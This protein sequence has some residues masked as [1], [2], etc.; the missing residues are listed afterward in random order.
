[1]LWLE[2]FTLW[3]QLSRLKNN[4]VDDKRERMWHTLEALCLCALNLQLL[5]IFSIYSWLKFE[6]RMLRKQKSSLMMLLV[7][8]YSFLTAACCSLNCDGLLESF[9]YWQ[10]RQTYENPSW[11]CKHQQETFA[12]QWGCLLTFFLVCISLVLSHV[13]KEELTCLVACLSYQ[14]TFDWL[15]VIRE[16]KMY[17]CSALVYIH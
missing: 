17:V 10:I 5:W 2:C 7:C 12:D 6:E 4:K 11:C 9:H 3:R 15:L 13:Q 1:M 14:V 8:V 16:E